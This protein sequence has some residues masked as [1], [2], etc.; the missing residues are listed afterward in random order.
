MNTPKIWFVINS[1]AGTLKEAER[2]SLL[3]SLKEK[4]ISKNNLSKIVF[5]EYANHA[6]LIAKEAID[7]KVDFLVAVGGDGT[8]NECASSLAG[9]N[10]AMGIIPIGSGNGLARHLGISL[11]VDTAIDQFLNGKIQKIDR[12]LINEIPFFCTAGVGFDAQ[13][14]KAF[15]NEKERGFKTYIKTTFQTFLRYKPQQYHIKI[16][17]QIFDTRAFAITFANANQYGNNAMVA[18]NAT[19]NDGW[20]D[21]C[22]LKPFPWWRSFDIVFRLF[23]GSLHRSSFMEVFRIQNAEIFCEEN[24]NIHFDGEP[25]E[26]DSQNLILSID[27]EVLNICC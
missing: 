2:A 16:V 23:T 8:I 13:V 24:A 7:Q 21:L 6:K 1:T 19:I 11:D 27:K 22:I 20:I 26:L 17:N 3:L 4:V 5:T 10:V 12:C 18:P 9:T 14:A 15:S 25:F